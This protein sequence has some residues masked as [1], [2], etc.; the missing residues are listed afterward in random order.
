MA[1]ASAAGHQPIVLPAVALVGGLVTAA[2]VGTVAGAY[3]AVRAGRLT[4]TEALRS[5]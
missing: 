2:V 3:P 4:P 1:V 5:A